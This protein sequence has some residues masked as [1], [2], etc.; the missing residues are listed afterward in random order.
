M[1]LPNIHCVNVVEP[2]RPGAR[3]HSVR[4][5][6]VTARTPDEAVRKVAASLSP[7]DLDCR[8]GYRNSFCE[9]DDLDTLAWSHQTWTRDDAIG[10]GQLASDLRATPAPAR[11]TLDQLAALGRRSVGDPE[12]DFVAGAV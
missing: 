12:D 4:L 11:F 8:V 6:L 10:Y 3:T 9:A 7:Y 5:V 2:R 1:P